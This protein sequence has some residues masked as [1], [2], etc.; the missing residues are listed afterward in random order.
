M[1]VAANCCVAPAAM[2]DVAGV[3]EIE[4]RVGGGGAVTVSE[5]VPLTPVRAAVM[6][7]DPAATA[8]ARPDALM[9]AAALLELV[10]VAVEDT[11]A[12][13]PSL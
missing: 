10:H 13:D 11:F 7:D 12:V 9:V 1:P 3:T 8:V 4:E 6:V 5:A 2:L